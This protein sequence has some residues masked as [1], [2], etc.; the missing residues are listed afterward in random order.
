MV[1]MFYN[2]VII[3]AS[4][5]ATPPNNDRRADRALLL[6]P[7]SLKSP[8]D[9]CIATGDNGAAI[10][11]WDGDDAAAMDNAAVAGT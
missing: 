6:L 1:V 9:S 2:M 10:L 11:S 3:V 7:T 5:D 4:S 8:S